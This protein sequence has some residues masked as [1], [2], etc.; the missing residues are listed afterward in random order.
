MQISTQAQTHACDA[1]TCTRKRAG[2]Y[3]IEVSGCINYMDVTIYHKNNK[4]L[5]GTELTGY[6][7]F[8]YPDESCLTEELAQFARTNS[9]RV[10]VPYPGFNNFKIALIINGQ[11]VYAF[12]DNDCNL[13]ATLQKK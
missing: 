10:K 6:A 4:P 11:T 12:F 3:Q 13:R 7:E 9:L 8:Y 2:S 5:A 1:N